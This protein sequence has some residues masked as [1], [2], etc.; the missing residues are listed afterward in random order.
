MT[1]DIVGFVERQFD[2]IS[3]YG[4]PHTDIRVDCP[5]CIDRVGKDDTKQK[6]FI[7]IHKPVVHCFRC[8]YSTTWWKFV[9]DV[10]GPKTRYID[11]YSELYTEPPVSSFQT[12]SN[13]FYTDKGVKP[14]VIEFSLPE[15]FQGL[16]EEPVTALSNLARN[17][18]RKRGFGRSYWIKYHLGVAMSV[19]WR[20][21][22]PIERD[23]WQARTL[24]KGVEPKYRNP[25]VTSQECIFNVE[26]ME[27]YQEV[28]V[29]EGA[30]SA[31]SV[32]SNAIALIRKKIVDEQ[33]VR[34]VKSKV[35][36]FILTIEPD[37]FKSMDYLANALRLA[38]KDVTLWTYDEGDP[39]DTAVPDKIVDYNLRTRVEMLLT[40]K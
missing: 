2:K 24:F 29:C 6:L 39:N 1:Y 37:A 8:D 40:V 7:S 26:A 12:V 31:M 34:L 9:R 21:I 4:S 27:I 16:W 13:K 3:Y 10:L 33:L 17:Y 20:L 28:V 11:I 32:G 15:D 23:Y 18:A 25:K 14:K 22:I 38:G 30:F 36:H 35:Q 19:G 5:F